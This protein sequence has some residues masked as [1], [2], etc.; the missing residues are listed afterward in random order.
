M[1]NGFNEY[2]KKQLIFIDKISNGYYKFMGEN[3]KK[4]SLKTV[5]L[6]CKAALLQATSIAV[7]LQG[8]W[9]VRA[10]GKGL[11]HHFPVW[12]GFTNQSLLKLPFPEP[13]DKLFSHLRLPLWHLYIGEPQLLDKTRFYLF[14]FK[15]D[16]FV[17]CD[18]F[19][20]GKS[21][22]LF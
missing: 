16:V 2:F 6:Q 18:C 11:L 9:L 10:I 21:L 1:I 22:A 12:K 4:F 13:C 17:P 14:Y 19:D 5:I 15:D 8:T 3:I 20:L 7:R